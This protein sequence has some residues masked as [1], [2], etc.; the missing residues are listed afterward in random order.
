MEAPTEKEKETIA[1]LEVIKMTLQKNS[2]YNWSQLT[3]AS[4]HHNRTPDFLTFT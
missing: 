4:E 1:T 3:Y 2:K